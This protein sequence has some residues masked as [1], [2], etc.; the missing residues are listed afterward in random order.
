[1]LRAHEASESLS[2]K[3]CGGSRESHLLGN[4]IEGPRAEKLFVTVSLGPGHMMA[5]F[6]HDTPTLKALE[7]M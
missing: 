1:M 5:Q 7:H 2:V 6:S 4:A 3:I